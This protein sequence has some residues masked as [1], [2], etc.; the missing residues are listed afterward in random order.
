MID[1]S[2]TD[3]Y[4]L[5]SRCVVLA[6]EDT[7][8]FKIVLPSGTVSRNPR[9]KQK[10]MG[11]LLDLL[12][13]PAVHQEER[14][15]FAARA[16]LVFEDKRL[17][18]FSLKQPFSG[19]TTVGTLGG[20]INAHAKNL[21]YHYDGLLEFPRIVWEETGNMGQFV[22]HLPPFSYLYTSAND[23]LLYL[24]F[25]QEDVRSL[26]ESSG[27]NTVHGF[28]NRTGESI[29]VRSLVNSVSA[30]IKILIPEDQ[31]P[32]VQALSTVSVVARMDDRAIGPIL[33]EGSSNARSAAAAL[34]VLLDS[35]AKSFGAQGDMF[36]A[37][38]SE[39]EIVLSTQQKIDKTSV[40]TRTKEQAKISIMVEFNK[41]TNDYLKNSVVLK[42]P[43]KMREAFT[44]QTS[45]KGGNALLT[46]K[47]LP[48][49]ILAEGARSYGYVEGLSFVPVIC[50]IDSRAV[51][52]SAMTEFNVSNSRL[53]LK[54]ISRSLQ[55]LKFPT[56][57]GIEISF[58]IQLSTRDGI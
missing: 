57:T 37:T 8:E 16:S 22:V 53:K 38:A 54:I 20:R 35:A 56:N 45:E 41:A 51:I 52:H 12:I 17:R 2:E 9:K 14:I 27:G 28:F 50:Y 44:F 4:F 40:P 5:R 24:G 21:A 48:F 11:Q 6:G 10:F 47:E 13:D 42:F 30:P 29:A 39:S 34:Q 19:E 43:L 55:V 32:T 25:K 58:K 49:T 1:C 3:L 18:S 15:T 23:Y 31:R 36:L 46:S 7:A 33:Q 26:S